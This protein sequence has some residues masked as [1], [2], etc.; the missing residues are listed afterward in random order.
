[1]D[2]KFTKLYNEYLNHAAD[3]DNEIAAWKKEA[4][5]CTNIEDFASYE[6]EIADL[7]AVKRALDFHGGTF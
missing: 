1:M 7:I 4:N 2:T 5:A 6:N 3:L